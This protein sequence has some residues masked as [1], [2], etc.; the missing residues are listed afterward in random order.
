MESRKWQRQKALPFSACHPTAKGTTEKEKA[1]CSRCINNNNVKVRD[2][3]H[4]S[5][6]F[7]GAAHSLCNLQYRIKAENWKLPVFMH[8][9][10]GYDSHM[11]IN[12]LKS[13]HGHIR[14]IP[15][16][17]QKYMSIQV[18]RVMF[19]DSMQFAG[20][21]LAELAKTLSEDD[22]IET[23]KLF[24]I[25]AQQRPPTIPHAH[26][27]DEDF[28]I[29]EDGTSNSTVPLTEY[30]EC[31]WCD[32]NRKEER[33]QQL[34]Q[35]GIFPYDY[36]N[37][38]DRMTET[39]LPDR[40]AFYNRLSDEELH[41]RDE[42]HANRVWELQ[43]CQALRDYHDFYLKTDVVIL[44]D[45]FEKFRTT[46]FEAYGLDAAHYYSAP[47]LAFDAALKIS[48]VSLELLDNATMYDFFES[49]IRG[50]ISQISL[51]HA[52]ANTPAAPQ[53]F[54]PNADHV[55]LI[56][57]D[58]NNLYGV[59][60][61]QPLPT[62][63]FRWLTPTEID[64]LNVQSLDD[65]AR[66]GYVLE[67][68]LEIPDHL[69]DEFNDLPPAP[70][71]L[72]IDETFLS[73]LQTK[74]PESA[75]KPQR[76]LAPNLLPKKNYV[77]HYRNLKF[78]MDMGCVVTKIH[79]ALSF[80]QE[81][82]LAKYIAY[83]TERRSRS[84]SEFEKDF[85]KLMNNSVFGKSQENLRKR[86]SV[87]VVTDAD[88]AAKRVCRPSMKRS[89]TI[90]E[91]LVVMEHFISRLELDRAV[92]TGFCVLELSK[93]W[94]YDFH[95]KKMRPW[96]SS[97]SSSIELLFTDTDSLCYKIRDPRNIYKVL[98]SHN[99]YFD[100]SDYPR[101]HFCFDTSNRKK[102]G[103]F[104]DELNSLCLE[105]FVGLR[106]KSY[107]I[108]FRGKVKNNAIVHLNEDVKKVAKGTKYGVKERHLRHAHYLDALHNWKTIYMRQNSIQSKNHKLASYHQCRASLTCFDTKRWILE[109]GI[110]TLAHGHYLTRKD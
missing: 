101:D 21:S 38:I 2:H 91:D 5:G 100:F 15:T 81:P 102:I 92:Y 80:N 6:E 87:E 56:Y 43:N 18:G 66:S 103:L 59:A 40:D 44:A 85:W 36:F 45:V 98:K 48:G 19:L 31:Q 34:F 63:G 78:Y 47:G 3:S 105:E 12:A 72:V 33:I 69:H 110:H 8:N 61:S 46:C 32:I 75:K 73:P 28:S 90:R 97:P 67:V 62:G 58:C 14:I 106:P 49:S 26:P 41:W 37:S 84:K 83:N 27:A 71:S 16:N 95:Y 99:E 30:G 79:R 24:G 53:T 7:V 42:R 89:L 70:E 60:M 104:T 88:V 13:K 10:S 9:F 35:K 74:F 54:D 107:S 108:K 51:R 20:K 4:T 94:M 82:W 77:T 76:K 50:G 65:F 96:F 22:F 93:L 25:P 29:R 11:I 55:Q 23:K 17:L 86:I 109:D 57:I 52:A 39:S 1:K 64:H 68:D